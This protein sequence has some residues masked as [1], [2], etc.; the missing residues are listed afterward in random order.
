MFVFDVE[1]LDL[2]STAVLLAVG[3]VHIKDGVDYDYESLFETGKFIKFSVE[4]QTGVR[5]ISKS[6]LQFWSEQEKE[7][8]KLILNR[9]H[10]DKT[11]FDGIIEL[12]DYMNKCDPTRSSMVFTRG[13]LDQMVWPSFCKSFNA[14]D[15][16]GYKRF[17]DVRTFV[18]C[19][20]GDTTGYCNINKKIIQPPNFMAHHPVHDVARDALMMLYPDTE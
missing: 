2:E 14:Y 4:A 17:R 13:P 5:S 15:P 1:T 20:T 9:S 16:I 18:D 7:V 8:R 3:M 6:T 11:P 12:K 19:I 10:E